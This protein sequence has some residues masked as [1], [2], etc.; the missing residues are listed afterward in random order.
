MKLKI[1][2]LCISFRWP[3]QIEDKCS[4]RPKTNITC[5]SRHQLK[6]SNQITNVISKWPIPT[7]YE[8]FD[9]LTIETFCIKE[10]EEVGYKSHTTGS[11][12]SPKIIL[13]LS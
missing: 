11:Y 13:S 6:I 7:I 8:C 1:Y 3:Y 12:H 2:V 5:K 4:T 10:G 9:A